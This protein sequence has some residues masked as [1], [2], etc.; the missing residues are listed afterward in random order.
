MFSLC[1]FGL[2]AWRVELIEHERA[3]NVFQSASL[4]HLF[5]LLSRFVCA[6]WHVSDVIFASFDLMLVMD[7]VVLA[8]WHIG[9]VSGGQL[10]IGTGTTMNQTKV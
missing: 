10:A 4:L 6:C 8:G 5:R 9:T 7:C 3:T 1:F 2:V